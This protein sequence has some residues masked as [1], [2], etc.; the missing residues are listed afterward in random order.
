MNNGSSV[1]GWNS[2]ATSGIYSTV[3]DRKPGAILLAKTDI[4]TPIDNT[5]PSL[6]PRMDRFSSTIGN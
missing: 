4:G 3:T 2:T 1:F 5:K 6:T